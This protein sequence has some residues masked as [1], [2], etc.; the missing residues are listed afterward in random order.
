VQAGS[1]DNQQ[2]AKPKRKNGV[3][4]SDPDI[5]GIEAYDFTQIVNPARMIS[6]NL[7]FCTIPRG[8]ESNNKYRISR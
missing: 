2:D 7:L 8:L 1:K 6:V 4:L 3:L 5:A